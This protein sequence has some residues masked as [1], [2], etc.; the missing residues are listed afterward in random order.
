MSEMH[1]FLSS[2]HEDWRDMLHVRPEGDAYCPRCEAKLGQLTPHGQLTEVHP[3][4]DMAMVM[5]TYNCLSCGLDFG[6]G[7]GFRTSRTLCT[8]Y[9]GLYL[10]CKKEDAG[11]RTDV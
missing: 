3:M 5:E 2:D 8:D 6:I 1:Q 4:L 11:G 7:I 9:K 10:A